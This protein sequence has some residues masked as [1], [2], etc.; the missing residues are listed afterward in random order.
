[1]LSWWMSSNGSPACF[2]SGRRRAM[3]KYV[4]AT[5]VWSLAVS[6]AAAQETTVDRFI[7]FRDGSVLRLPV[8]DEAWKVTG[9]LAG[10]KIG[11]RTVRLS[12]IQQ[13]TLTAERVFDKKRPVLLAIQQLGSDDFGERE[14]AQADLARMG[15]EIRPDL[16]SALETASDPEV[17]FRL[18]AILEKAP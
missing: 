12:T 4:L 15:G 8:V 13:L 3:R 1:S 11:A 6:A 16:E 10:G 18:K 2:S 7:E 5:V 17:V 9:L 14:Q